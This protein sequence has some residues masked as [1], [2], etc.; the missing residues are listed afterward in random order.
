MRR[1]LV[2][3]LCEGDSLTVWHLAQ[4]FS[5]VDQDNDAA[6]GWSCAAD[7]KAGWWYKD[8]HA[9]NLNGLYLAGRHTSYANGVEWSDWTGQHY[10]L[11]VSEMK[12]RPFSD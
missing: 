9:S 12:I 11:R 10:S 4:N 7:Y 8:C 2:F 6:P 5:T 1:F 3:A